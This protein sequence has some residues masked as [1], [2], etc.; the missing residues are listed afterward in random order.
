MLPLGRIVVGPF[1]KVEAGFDEVFMIFE[2]FNVAA[3]IRCRELEAEVVIPVEAADAALEARPKLVE[4]VDV[5]EKG[6]A[7]LLGVLEEG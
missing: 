7:A 1:P 2:T 3:G 4:E 5:V 6:M